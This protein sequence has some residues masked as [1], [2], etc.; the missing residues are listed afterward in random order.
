MPRAAGGWVTGIIHQSDSCGVRTHGVCF[1][2]SKNM[3]L[4][5][6]DGTFSSFGV[7]GGLNLIGALV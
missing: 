4:S 2:H 7:G 6:E 1:L 3:L 5:S